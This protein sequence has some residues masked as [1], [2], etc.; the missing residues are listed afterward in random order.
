MSLHVP[1]HA[2]ASAVLD[3]AARRAPDAFAAGG[4]LRNLYAGA[5]HDTGT[6]TALV[7]PV[8]GTA[9]VEMAKVDA[10]TAQEAVAAAGEAHRDWSKV[11]LAQ[12]RERVVAAVEALAEARDDLALLLAWEIG[13][14]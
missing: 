12:R 9:I 10:A 14:P 6:P 7:T 13:K 1:D 5:W 3:R 2:G 11:P 8:D 4:R